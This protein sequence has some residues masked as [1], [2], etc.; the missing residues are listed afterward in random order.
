MPEVYFI[1][2]VREPTAFEALKTTV[3]S[4]AG[5]LSQQEIL[6]LA[7]TLQDVVRARR[8]AAFESITEAGLA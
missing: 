3:V 8:A 4:A 5:R 2:D 6:D 7:D 1:D